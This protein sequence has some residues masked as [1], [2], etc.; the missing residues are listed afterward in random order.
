MY[1]G[2]TMKNI[3]K[4]IIIFLVGGLGYGIIEITFRGFTHWSMIITGGSAFLILYLLNESI[5][6]SIFLKAVV[7]ASII[8][9]LEFTVGIIINKYFQLGVW[10]YTGIPLNI[11]GQISPT[12]SLCWYGISIV[13][14]TLFDL[15]KYLRKFGKSLLRE[16]QLK[17]SKSH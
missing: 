1:Q 10:D 11:M 9:L 6:A 14:F 3:E 8:T 7:G 17:P 12:F 5:I 16:K 2:D 15:I 13:S 4:N